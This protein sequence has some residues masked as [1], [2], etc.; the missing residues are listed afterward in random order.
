[1]LRMSS[2]PAS[3]GTGIE[4]SRSKRPKRR[5]A[6][7][8]TL[9]R[10]VAAITT[11]CELALSPSSSVSSCETIRRSTSPCALSRPASGLDRRRVGATS[12]VQGPRPEARGPRRGLGRTWRDGVDLIDEDD[13]GGVLLR[14]VEC[15]AEVLL[16]LSSHLAHH[17]R[18]VDQEERRALISVRA[19]AHRSA[20]ESTAPGTRGT[21]SPPLRPP[22]PPHPTPHNPTLVSYRS[23]TKGNAHSL[24][25]DR[26][27]DHRLAA[28][29]RAVD[30]HAPRRA[31]AHR[32]EDL[33]VAHGQFHQLADHGEL[34]VAPSDVVVAELLDLLGRGWEWGRG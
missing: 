9:G 6:G 26:P 1:M 23:N 11:T 22:G 12:K 19:R 30:E 15:R 24:G 2:R 28:A 34:L 8:S 25:D 31:H 21:R 32:R 13:R 33:G 20:Q 18:P 7:S 14:L 16:R 3:S 10:L 5:S 17:L 4:I 29:G 27:G